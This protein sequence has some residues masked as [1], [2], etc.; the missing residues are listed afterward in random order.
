MV[1]WS[2]HRVIKT[3]VVGD[4]M[5]E[6]EELLLF[7]RTRIYHFIATMQTGDSIARK[8]EIVATIK[9]LANRFTTSHENF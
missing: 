7:S 1:S 2:G 6:E 8:L 4:F 9:L 5:D 3:A